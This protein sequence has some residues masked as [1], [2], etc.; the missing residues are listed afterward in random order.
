MQAHRPFN[1]TKTNLPFLIAK[2]NDLLDA[3]GNWQVLIK[4]RNSDRSLEQN[5]RLWQLYTSIGN[6]TGNSKNEMHEYFGDEFL[7]ESKIIMG[8]PVITIKSTSELNVAEMADYQ[9]KIEAFASNLGWSF[10]N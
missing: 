4:E 9:M 8:K 5:A 1:I 6:F 3:G 10:E 7:K 2:L